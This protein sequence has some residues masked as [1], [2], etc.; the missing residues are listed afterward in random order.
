M[1]KS[2]I[3]AFLSSSS[4]MDGFNTLAENE[5]GQVHFFEEALQPSTLYL[6]SSLQTAMFSILEQVL[7]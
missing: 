3:E 4:Q 5:I 2:T 1:T 7:P 6:H